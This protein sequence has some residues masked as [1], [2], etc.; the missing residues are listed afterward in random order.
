MSEKINTTKNKYKRSQKFNDSESNW[1][2]ADFLLTK[3]M[4]IRIN[5]IK[6]TDEDPPISTNNDANKSNNDVNT[7]NI[8]TEKT[9]TNANNSNNN[10]QN[11]LEN[12][13]NDSN[14]GINMNQLT[15]EMKNKLLQNSPPE[16]KT[17]KEAANWF[18][19]H[20]QRRWE[21]D[22]STPHPEPLT[23]CEKIAFKF[24]YKHLNSQKQL[25]KKRKK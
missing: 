21:H 17:I 10:N 18:I 3:Q 25:S 7:E 14:E 2:K 22:K 5:H 4:C 16:C 15:E 1:C 23:D 6:S 8:L 11:N 20:C 24:F 13:S 12:N 19:Q 9:T